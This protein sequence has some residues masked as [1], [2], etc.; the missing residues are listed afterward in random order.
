M[1]QATVEVW[2]DDS[3]SAVDSSSDYV[4]QSLLLQKSS[5][6]QV[7]PPAFVFVH[8]L[9]LFSVSDVVP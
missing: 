4:P 3:E 7:M 8:F 1:T 9:L 5:S 6:P 2:H